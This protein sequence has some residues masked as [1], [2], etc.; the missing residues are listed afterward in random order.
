MALT[1]S[2]GFPSGSADKESACSAGDVG[3]TLGREEPL[4]EEMATH[5]ST[6][7]WEIPWTEEPDGLQSIGVGK[8]WTRLSN[9]ALTSLQNECFDFLAFEYMMLKNT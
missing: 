8:S 3:L 1:T 5:S 2:E 9:W 6:L 7:A 4:E